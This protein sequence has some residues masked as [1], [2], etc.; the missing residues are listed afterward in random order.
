MEHDEVNEHPILETNRETNLFVNL[1]DEEIDED[2]PPLLGRESLAR[3][4]RLNSPSAPSFIDNLVIAKMEQYSANL[5]PSTVTQRDIDVLRA[6]YQIPPS[7][8]L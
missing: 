7:I 6:R 4:P 2:C 5:F 1:S 8:T 3:F